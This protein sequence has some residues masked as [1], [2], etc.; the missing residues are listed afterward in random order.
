MTCLKIV[1]TNYANMMHQPCPSKTV[2]VLSYG[3]SISSWSLFSINVGSCSVKCMNRMILKHEL[4]TYSGVVWQILFNA[5]RN[6]FFFSASSQCLLHSAFPGTGW[7]GH[8][9]TYFSLPEKPDTS[10]GSVCIHIGYTS[11][12]NPSSDHKV[13]QPIKFSYRG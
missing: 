1:T 13:P 6:T 3:N 7:L 10:M 4:T 11:F 5:C 8:E 2:A 12:H 9:S